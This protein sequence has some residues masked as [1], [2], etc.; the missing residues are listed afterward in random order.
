M[1][2]FRFLFALIAIWA[3]ANLT[4]A[5]KEVDVPRV[6]KTLPFSK[7]INLT[8]WLAGEQPDYVSTYGKQ[9]FEDIKSLGADITR[10]YIRFEEFSSGEPDFIIPDWLWKRIDDAV[11]WCTELKLYIII[12]FHNN[13]DG[14]SKTRPDVEKMLEKIWTQV[15]SR[16]KDSSEYVLY[17][18]LNEPHMKS[19]NIA[20]DV[21]KWNKIQGRI[22]KLIR[23]I[24]TKHTVIVGAEDWN[25]VTQLL[26]LPDYKDNNIILNF[27][28]YSPFLFTTQGAD[29]C[30][31][32]EVRHIP[33]PYSKEKMPKLP[34]NVMPW[35]KN[36]Y[37]SYKNDS[38]EATLVT[39]LDEA[40]K[41]ANKRGVALMCNEYGVRM[42]YADPDER[43]NWYRL[44]V[45]W[46]DERNIIRLS[47]SYRESFGIYNNPS[48]LAIEAKFPEDLNTDIINAMGYNTFLKPQTHLTWFE[49]AKKTGDYTIYKNGFA[50]GLSTGG[51][52]ITRFRINKKDSADGE[53]FI[54][55]PKADSFAYIKCV[56]GEECDFTSLVNSGKSLEFEVRSN[57]KNL[58]LLLH[59]KNPEIPEAGKAGLP[60][61]C[62]KNENTIPADGKWHKISIPLKD[63]TQDGAYSDREQKWYN[64]EGLFSW[65]K[66]YR[67]EFDFGEK[68]LQNDVSIRN[69]A[70]K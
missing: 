2:K 32:G 39:P 1:K 56:F 29:Y 33:F 44:K 55:A 35:V 58:N 25:S 45:K 23:T 46:M 38:S 57:Q 30:D 64:A 19:G 65:S 11:A 22:L 41:F 66:V 50:K 49:N 34:Q 16:Y 51:W 36:S 6:N 17:E 12:D 60:W 47:H 20:A 8:C 67:L 24:D 4:L 5:A 68:G 42:E 9:D 3:F 18:I 10:L 54:H 31:L 21:S 15:A 37:N 43:T 48:L 63:F 52:N 53:S 69:I 62:T 59:F 40:V 7:G 26:K 70:I 61:S 28:D 14:D 13:C 27:H